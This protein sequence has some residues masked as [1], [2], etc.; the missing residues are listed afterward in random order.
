MLSKV[1]EPQDRL[2]LER[3]V[4]ELE[5]SLKC[6]PDD[7][8]SHYNLGN[9]YAARGDARPALA[10]YETAM[11]LASATLPLVNA[12]SVYD[13]IGERAGPTVC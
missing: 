9:Y 4:H 7:Y 3:A 6:R 8:A 1:L 13:A 12:S 11:K 5:D 2:K 10:E